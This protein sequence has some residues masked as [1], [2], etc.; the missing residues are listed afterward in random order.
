MSDRK[1]TPDLMSQILAG[2]SP[3]TERPAPTPDTSKAATQ[4]A[5]ST[6]RRS[7]GST[8]RRST[9]LTVNQQDDLP[10][11]QQAGK[12][13]DTKFKGTYYL[14]TAGADAIETLS[15]SLR[16]RLD[17]DSRSQVNKSLIVDLALQIVLEDYESAGRNSLIARR[18]GL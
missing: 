16:Q 17:P 15:F 3:S 18:L 5:S 10:S 8:A 7:T 13:S 11:D 14:S 4:Q 2:D 9:S 6:A 12:P 1:K